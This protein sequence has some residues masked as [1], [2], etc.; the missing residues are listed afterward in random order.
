[1]DTVDK[2]N[3]LSTDSQYDLACACGTRKGDHRKRGEDG[4][5]LYPVPLARGGYG[6]MLK[7][8][9][10]NACSSDC[11]YCPL[12]SESNVRRCSLSPEE[13]ARVFMDFLRRKKLIGLFLSSGVI[14]TPDMTMSKLN[15]VAEIL[16]KKYHYRG[17]IHLKIIPGASAAAIEHSLSLASAVSLNIE[18]PGVRYF[19]KLSAYKDFDRDIISP[20]KYMADLTRRGMKYS[21]VKCTTQFIVGAADEPD[22]EIVRYMDGIYN[23]LNFERVYFSAYQPG[24]G[25]RSIPGEQNFELRPDDRF[26]R[27][28]RLYQVD[29]LMRS[30]G[31]SRDELIFRAD[32]NLA[33][34][35]DPKQIWADNHPELFPLNIN[36]VDREALLRVPGIGPASADK[37]IKS[38][39]VHQLRDLTDVGIKGKLRKKALSYLVFR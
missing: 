38:R 35:K 7:T 25:D 24:L 22:I 14:G 31:F 32:G 27:E 36:A 37:I 33:L 23:R 18:T 21:R 30:Y 9:L 13:T 1:M 28:H 17:Y 29:F 4:H 16:R 3:I 39:S 15:A 5:W 20:V 19:Q 26:T 12:R 2:L 11:R 8:L 10:S 34:D 6:I